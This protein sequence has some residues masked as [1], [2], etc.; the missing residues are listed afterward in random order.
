MS[1]GVTLGLLILGPFVGIAVAARD[2]DFRPLSVAVAAV[3]GEF[4]GIVILAGLNNFLV[5]RVLAGE[6]SGAVVYFPQRS[7]L[8]DQ[9]VTVA[10]ILAYALA[11]AAVVLLGRLLYV[12]AKQ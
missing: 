11:V 4:L 9:L 12:R 2:G 3:V 5:G 7:S 10:F 8:S 6:R 1:S